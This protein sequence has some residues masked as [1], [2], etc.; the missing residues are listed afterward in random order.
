MKPIR[1]HEL[2]GVPL[3]HPPDDG[4]SGRGKWLKVPDVA[5]Q[6]GHQGASVKVKV[7]NGLVSAVELRLPT[8]DPGDAHRLHSDLLRTITND[9]EWDAVHKPRNGSMTFRQ[10]RS[11]LRIGITF[12]ADAT[13]GDVRVVL[14]QTADDHP[15]AIERSR[16]ATDQTAVAAQQLLAAILGD[17]Q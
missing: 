2:A 7:D 9:P 12:R 10:S 4:W 16:A 11:Q 14:Q 8:L 17:T 3:G 13:I 15:T 6:F 1:P 5:A